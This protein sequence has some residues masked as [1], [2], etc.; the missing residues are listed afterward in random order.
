MLCSA[1]PVSRKSKQPPKNKTT[2]AVALTNPVPKDETTKAALLP[3]PAKVEWTKGTCRLDAA[4]R[5][6]Y[7]GDGA[8]ADADALATML[9]PATGLPLDVAPMGNVAGELGNGIVLTLYPKEES[10]TGEEG[11]RLTAT[12]PGVIQ[13]AASS[14]AGLFYG[15]Q[16]LRQLLP[17]AIYATT[18][19]EGVKWEIPCCRIEDK[20][21]FPWR[22][23]LLDEARHFFG[24]EFVKVCIDRMAAHKLNTLHWHLTDDQ[25]WRIDIKKYPKITQ[26]GSWRAETTGDGKRYGGFY[27]QDEIREIVAYAA[28]R[29]VTIV[30]E[31]EMPGHALGALSAYPEF[32][33][34]GGPFKVR[35]KWGIED[36]V[37]CAGNEG[38]FKFVED[39]LD[40]V[41]ALFPS[42]YIHIGGDECPKTRWKACPKCQARIKAEGLKDEHQLQGYFT[43]RIEKYLDSKGRRLIGWDEIL[44]GGLPPK[45]TVMSWRGMGGALA[46]ARTGHDYVATPTSHCYLDYSYSRISLEKAYSL[47]PVPAELTAQQ[48]THCLGVQGNMWS[49]RTPDAAAIDRQTWPRLCALAEVG[50][51][52]A[53]SRNTAEFLARMEGHARRLA[54]M[55]I[56]QGNATLPRLEK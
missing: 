34:R 50:W 12:P 8:K 20:P 40:E 32:S 9:R 26:I 1:K 4:T 16:T 6:F 22:G 17:S 19:Q 44:E 51:T 47:D 24:K 21:R 2:T 49:E 43:R 29:H 48:R 38:T 31:I 18:K 5:I 3:R 27:T 14:P 33:C 46:A 54:A 10:A 37:L 25:G 11:Y 56:K 42:T 35:T 7:V 13:I 55:G 39:I 41:L 28:A 45:A 30:P 36:D 23:F 53:E 52:P 15:G